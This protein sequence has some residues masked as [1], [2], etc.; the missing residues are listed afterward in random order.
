MNDNG[1][2]ASPDD[3]NLTVDGGSVLSGATNDVSAGAHTA[4]ETNLPGY[5]AGVW[6]GDCAADGSITLA[7]DEDATCTITNDD[8]SPTLT[9][10]KTVV[11]DNG[12]DASPDDFNL[13]VDGGSVLS[14]AT[15]D[16]S[17]G[18]HTAAETNLPGYSAG[19][20]GGDCAADGSITLA[21]DEDATCTITN[22]D[23]SP[24][25]TL[26]KT[27]VN[28]N[29]GDASPDDFNLTV[30]GGSVLSGATND[31]SAGAHTAAE[32]NLPGY[33]AGVW[34]GDCA[35]DG[36][37]TLALDEDATCT[38]TN[39]D[40]P[41]HLTLI[42]VVTGD[43][44]T[45]N[46]ANPSQWTLTATGPTTFSGDG[47]VES[48]VNAGTYVLTEEG[49][50]GYELTSLT[51]DN[52]VVQDASINLGLGDDVTCTFVN[53]RIDLSHEFIK[54]FADDVVLVDTQSSFDLTYTNTGEATLLDVVISDEIDEKLS[55]DNVSPAGV[56]TVVGS[57]P[58]ILT[59]DVGDVDPLE[60]VTITVNFT[61]RA[62]FNALEVD[63]NQKKGAQY[64]FV[65]ENGCVLQG[66]TSDASSHI[67]TCDGVVYDDVVTQSKGGQDIVFTPPFG[68]PAFT[69]HLS[70]SEPFIDGFAQNGG[71][72]PAA[73]PQWQV[74]EYEIDRYHKR[75]G[76]FKECGQV[77]LP[78]D[79]ENTAEAEVVT[80]FMPHGVF[81][82]PLVRSDMVTIDSQ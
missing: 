16:V 37:I 38:I 11:N 62:V 34:G 43:A 30:D 61:A 31:V 68:G 52:A 75:K 77:F 5:S 35:A 59:C 70:C 8:I 42:K 74:S 46:L 2:D 12:G 44:E 57:S 66:D 9:L 15:N 28:D 13:T 47:F 1:G 82:N 81:E 23:I 65:F 63:P 72:T 49:P 27:V 10:I 36:S 40:I 21:L 60:T 25:L 7:L 4:A 39:D 41:A 76:L 26:I 64:I 73:N 17:A 18:A 50:E 78:I 20:W 67:L 3:F 29:G 80:P 55:V 48:D 19:V 51:C 56:C 79:V 6:G 14:G 53:D 32:T 54:Q 22:D 69:M 58:Q 71:P 45:G 24:T 33:S